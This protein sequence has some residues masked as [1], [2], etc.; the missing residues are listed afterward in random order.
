MNGRRNYKPRSD[1]AFIHTDQSPK[2]DFE[3]S[4]QGIMTLTDSGENQ[5]GFVCVPKSHKYHQ[6]FFKK[7]KLEN[8][9]DNWY[10]FTDKDK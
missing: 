3:W 8:H 4:Y 7:N 2:K 6:E 1:N 5:G 10:L 9:K